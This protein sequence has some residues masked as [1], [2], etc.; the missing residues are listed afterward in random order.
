MFLLLWVAGE[1]DSW[2]S[3]GHTLY[4][5][6]WAAAGTVLAFLGW[7][8]LTK[9]VLTETNHV[10]SNFLSVQMVLSLTLAIFTPAFFAIA[11]GKQ[12][13]SLTDLF[14]MVLIGILTTYGLYA[15]MVAVTIV[16]KRSNFL[17]FCTLAMAVV[18]FIYGIGTDGITIIAILGLGLAVFGVVVIYINETRKNET[19]DY[20][21]TIPLIG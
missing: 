14:L 6:Q 17:L 13:T 3:F 11:S 8:K 15:A 9:H 10:S 1:G 2:G 16:K 21:T 5:L 19:I 12:P 4:G 20:S 7:R 18:L